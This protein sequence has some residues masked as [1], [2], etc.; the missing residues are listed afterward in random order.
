MQHPVQ[1]PRWVTVME[2]PKLAYTPDECTAPE[3]SPMSD[4]LRVQIVK[5]DITV[6]PTVSR[7][8]TSPGA[9]RRA[10]LPR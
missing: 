3:P 9:L 8:F 6:A 4:P 7:A 10:V 5:E 2:P 1:A